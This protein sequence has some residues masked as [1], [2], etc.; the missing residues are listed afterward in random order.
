[1]DI[2][3]IYHSGLIVSDMDRSIEFYTRVLGL[4]VERDPAE[5]SGEWI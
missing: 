4:N 5:A 3:T 1:M 2:E